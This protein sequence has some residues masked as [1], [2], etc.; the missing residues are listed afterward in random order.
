MRQLFQAAAINVAY[1]DRLC[2]PVVNVFGSVESLD[3]ERYQG[4]HHILEYI[5]SW[6]NIGFEAAPGDQAVVAPFDT[7]RGH[8]DGVSLVVWSPDGDT[9]ATCSGDGTAKLWDLRTLQV[10]H[11]LQAE[12]HKF[13][14]NLNGAPPERSEMS[15]DALAWSP[16]GTTITTRAGTAHRS[17]VVCV[18]LWDAVTGLPMAVSDGP[19]HHTRSPAWNPDET[20]V[21]TKSDDGTVRLWGANGT[22]R[23]VLHGHSEIVRSL[24]WT[25]DGKSLA[26]AGRDV[27][28]WNLVTGTVQHVLQGHTHWVCS[29]SFSPA[30][31][32]LASGSL[33]ET[34]RLWDTATGKNVQVLYGHSG[35]VN[36][37][38]W[39]PDG[40]IV[41]TASED[42]TARLWYPATR[43]KK[44]IPPTNSSIWYFEPADDDTATSED[45]DWGS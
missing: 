5:P 17:G 38:S 30:G 45:F 22:Q 37:V 9:L 32:T 42:H 41:A 39:S 33:D 1:I 34:V 27:R 25:P 16:D 19:M 12:Y 28:L 29:L 18:R 13:V 40:A 26:T 4:F 36:H 8:D 43:E 35:A 20:M 7:L 21:A 31:T 44:F 11:V 23:M 10:S 24:A 6:R 15:V 3:R 14:Q 2:E